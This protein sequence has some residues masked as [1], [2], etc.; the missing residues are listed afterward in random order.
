[1]SEILFAKMNNKV[2][3]R[4]VAECLYRLH[5]PKEIDRYLLCFRNVCY[6]KEHC[7]RTAHEKH[8]TFAGYFE[9]DYEDQA[10]NVT[11]FS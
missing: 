1:M 10:M 7:S 8:E 6:S 9:F 4:I 3:Q 2:R 5:G 11:A